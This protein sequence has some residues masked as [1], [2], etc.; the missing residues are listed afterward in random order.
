MMNQYLSKQKPKGLNVFENVNPQA[1]ITQFLSRKSEAITQKSMK[2][3]R[4][5]LHISEDPVNS[6][7]VTKNFAISYD[8]D[9]SQHII[10]LSDKMSR[11]QDLRFAKN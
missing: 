9:S 11:N 10:R 5:T 2:F 7:R 3:D 8:S 4:E 6:R 1:A